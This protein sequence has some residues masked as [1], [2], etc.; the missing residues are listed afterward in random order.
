MG[1]LSAAYCLPPPPKSAFNASNASTSTSAPSASSTH[2][3]VR[4]YL[5]TILDNPESRKI[6]YFLLL[7]LAYM[8]VQMVWGI[9]SGSLGLISDGE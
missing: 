2:R 5:K 7:N 1:H 9:W 4:T 8:L 6:Y 3:L